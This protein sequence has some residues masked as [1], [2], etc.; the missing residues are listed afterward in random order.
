MPAGK[1][2]VAKSDN[3][4]LCLAVRMASFFQRHR[5]ALREFQR[6]LLNSRFFT[7]SVLIHLILVAAFGGTVLFHRYV[8]PP[9]FTGGEA[10]GF[11]APDTSATPPQPQQ[12]AVQQPT[13]QVTPQ[14]ATAQPLQAI[15]S[16]APTQT[17][18]NLPTVVAPTI[19]PNVSRQLT[20]VAPAAPTMSGAI[21][22]EIASGIAGFTSGWSTG[23]GG[24][25]GSSLRSREFVFTAYLAKYS[26]GDWDST[27]KIRKEKGDTVG[28]IVGGSLPNLLYVINKLSRDKI[29]AEPNA[30]PLDLASE[31][32][33]AKKPPFIFFTGHRDFTLNEREVENLRKYLRLGGC[34]WGDSSLPGLRSRFDLAF[35]REMR[36]VVADKDKDFEPLPETHDMFTKGYFQEVRSVPAGINFYKESVYALKV[37]DEI[38]VLYTPND[39]GNMWQIGIN[40]KGQIEKGRDE[41]GNLV[42]LPNWW[43]LRDIYFRNI[44]DAAVFAT[45]KF[46]T[47][48][49]VHLLTRWED[50]VRNV[51]K[52]L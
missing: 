35:R 39:Y 26:G 11:V 36:R 15:T 8:E 47:N 32:I 38:A 43:D 21:P 19:A 34:I 14:T 16:A 9:D 27:V 3:P 18:F 33:F 28:K 1:F 31:E 13:F 50:K 51:P 4:A 49:I 7:I 17:A 10:G 42:A 52:G 29:K 45:Y 48:V 30:V 44:E 20:Q 24:G 25:A 41:K 22:R 23:G 12:Q 2:A 40:E 46:G 5:R 6:R 37:Y